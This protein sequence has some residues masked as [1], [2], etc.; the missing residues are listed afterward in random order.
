M[1]EEQ[2][3]DLG[4]VDLK[5]YTDHDFIQFH[6]LQSMVTAALFAQDKPKLSY[7]LSNYCYAYFVYHVLGG[8][9]GGGTSYTSRAWY[10]FFVND[11]PMG[12]GPGAIDVAEELVAAKIKYPIDGENLAGL[13]T[14]AL[15]LTYE[16]N[17]E[18]DLSDTYRLGERSKM[19][20]KIEVSSPHIYDMLKYGS[21]ADISA[22][23][24]VS[25][26][27]V[28]CEFVISVLD[29]AVH[30]TSTL[31]ADLKFFYTTTDGHRVTRNG[32]LDSRAFVFMCYRIFKNAF[33]AHSDGA[34]GDTDTSAPI[35]LNGSGPGAGWG[36]TLP[37]A[38]GLADGGQNI[39]TAEGA[40]RYVFF[41]PNTF[42]Q[43]TDNAYNAC[44]A[45]DPDGLAFHA[46]SDAREDTDV[47]LRKLVTGL[48]HLGMIRRAVHGAR[49]KA[50]SVTVG[51]TAPDLLVEFFPKG[52]VA[53]E[54]GDQEKGKTLFSRFG[55]G[56]IANV[57][58]NMER[59]LPNKA[60]TTSFLPYHQTCVMKQSALGRLPAL[61]TLLSKTFHYASS[62]ENIFDPSNAK[63]LCIGMPA[64]A[65]RAMH[66]PS[67]PLSNDTIRTGENVTVGSGDGHYSRGKSL[68]KVSI[69]KKDALLPD[70]VF[71]DMQFYYDPRLFVAAGGFDSVNT[72][73]DVMEQ[74][75]N[76]N[77]KRVVVE[78]ATGEVSVKD[79]DFDYEDGW[80]NAGKLNSLSVDVAKQVAM[81]AVQSDLLN[82]YLS[83]VCGM[84][85]DE[86]D[87]QIEE[88]LLD[89]RV[90]TNMSLT[91]GSVGVI[92]VLR[93]VGMID[94]AATTLPV[95]GD[96]ID[97]M[98]TDSVAFGDF[99]IQKLKALSTLLSET[100]ASGGGV[101]Q[102]QQILS[103]LL[104]SPH[105]TRT[106]LIFPRRFDG[107][108]FCLI[109]PDMFKVL[110]FAPD[111]ANASL[112]EQTLFDANI[113]QR[114]PDGDD[115]DVYL[116]KT[117]GNED[118]AGIIELN[119]T[120]TP[121][122]VTESEEL[123]NNPFAFATR[124][125]QEDVL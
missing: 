72:T 97:A 12:I 3:F 124:A 34:G 8:S 31:G 28:F 41:I 47:Q 108:V 57:Y 62:E 55:E 43:R 50:G 89:Q 93:A 77:F 14:W 91:A 99:E 45:T 15:A 94:S 20:S 74:L 115:G 38:C 78:A 125:P 66:K 103:S 82:F 100:D 123:S 7:A 52:T 49:I 24:Y 51:T 18:P 118:A 29:D 117:G 21:Q 114:Y 59:Q 63:I 26:F 92:D 46:F 87:L 60:D 81:T 6:S 53:G 90:D 109:D 116:L 67:T 39:D 23:G 22:A 25:A 30:R 65:T 104:F 16:T 112:I 17:A 32:G 5:S 44:E 95:S 106:E 54:A 27:D 80:T 120:V 36:G 64:G 37:E 73:M 122:D 9:P 2:F 13:V 42:S 33:I 79:A 56:H 35:I 88:D 71:E 83:I 76:V 102:M 119:A 85:L 61:L 70:V 68:F 107:V 96:V 101:V 86:G 40:D 48:S 121:V 111:P 69:T 113:A 4:S 84:E 98:F 110:E 58:K 75:N 19:T 11:G 105:A 1:P 10:N